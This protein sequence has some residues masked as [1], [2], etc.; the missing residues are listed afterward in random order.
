MR[1]IVMTMAALALL[2]G[3][4]A[5]KEAPKA[6]GGNSA[7]QATQQIDPE[8]LE[9]ARKLLKVTGSDKLAEQM[10]H[11]MVPQ[12]AGFLIRAKPEKKDEIVKILKEVVKKQT[13]P[14]VMNRLREQL[15][16]IYAQEFTTGEMKKIIAF[17]ETPVGKKFVQKMPVI[18]ARSQRAGM[19]WSREVGGRIIEQTRKQAKAKGIDLGGK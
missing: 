3:P 15:A 8:R 6:P 19:M 14:E 2:L 4:A 17:F 13:T 1:K 5:G 10:V 9:T 11:A 18:M 7:A 16:R 12:I